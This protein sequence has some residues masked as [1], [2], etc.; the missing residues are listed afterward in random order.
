[1]LLIVIFAVICGAEDCEGIVDFGRAKEARLCTFLTLRYGIPCGET[2]RRIFAALNPETLEDCLM[3]WLKGWQAYRRGGQVAVDGKR[4]RRSFDRASD[5][6]A[7]HMIGAWAVASAIRGCAV[8]I[9]ESAGRHPR[10]RR[11][12]AE[13][14]GRKIRESS[15]TRP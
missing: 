8:H 12:P 10:G 13:R 7:I 1:M 11:R 14:T 3:R 9:A 6:A 2:F 15:R 5:K 4:L